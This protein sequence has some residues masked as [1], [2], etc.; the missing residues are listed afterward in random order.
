MKR[1]VFLLT[2][3]L[4]LSAHAYEERGPSLQS[5]YM[6]LD[7]T[8]VSQHF[9]FY[10]LYPDTPI[11][12]MALRHAWEL[13]Q[14]GQSKEKVLPSIQLQPLIAFVNRLPSARDAP[15]LDEE[16]L[17]TIEKLARHLKNRNLKGFALWDPELLKKLNSDEIDLARGLFLAEMEEDTPDARSKIRSYEAN[18]DLMALQILA[19]LSDNASPKEKIRAINDYVFT[20]MRFRFPPHSLYAKDI[21]VYTLLPSVLDSRRG[22]CLGVSILYL[23]L[24]Q[25]LD[26]SLEAI[27][28]PGH[29]FVRH[30]DPETAEIINI[31]TTAR[32]INVPSEAYLGIET[33]TLQKRSIKDVIGLAFMNQASVS[34]HRDDSETA[35]SLYL[36]SLQYLQ[37]DYL[38]EMFLG[39]NYLFAGKTKEGKALLKKIQK[40]RPT[41][42]LSGDS[43]SEDYLAGKTDE[44]GIKAVFQEVNETRS[45]ILAKQKQLETVL[46]KFPEF[47]QGILHLAITYLQLGREKEALPILER[48]ISLRPDDPT[49][50]YYLSA[51]HLQRINFAMAWKYLL[52]AETILA[53]HDHRPKALKDLR[54]ALLRACP[55]PKT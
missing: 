5:V 46:A 22:V 44:E 30:V 52:R 3:F 41:H 24:A 19:R 32:G 31:E 20:E 35:I 6:S 43:V 2:I 29:I 17:Q 36:K 12:K 50:N 49:G 10:E 13:L 53:T 7:P 4:A 45:S 16:H 28:P 33:P 15:L 42:I 11:G 21:D 1:L 14:G 38:I 9:A 27:T 25:R 48:Y 54:Q 26:L 51:I 8:S 40:T 39:F 47:R 18:I 34:W 37:D 55:E 23:C